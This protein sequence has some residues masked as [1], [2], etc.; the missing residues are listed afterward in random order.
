M[1]AIIILLKS[2]RLGSRVRIALHTLHNFSLT[3]YFT[4]LL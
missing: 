3:L 2:N 4:G 1:A